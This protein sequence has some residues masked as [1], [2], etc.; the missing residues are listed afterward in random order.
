MTTMLNMPNVSSGIVDSS[1]ISL[2]AKLKKL[3]SDFASFKVQKSAPSGITLDQIQNADLELQGEDNFNTAPTVDH[4]EVDYG[5][6]SSV[7]GS[8]ISYKP[9]VT[10]S[11]GYFPS[12]KAP[13]EIDAEDSFVTTNTIGNKILIVYVKNGVLTAKKS[14]DFGVTWT[15]CNISGN[16][17]ITPIIVGIKIC[18]IESKMYIL[19][20]DTSS[21]NAMRMYKSIDSG[22]SFNSPGIIASGYE[23]QSFDASSDA[24]VLTILYHVNGTLGAYSSLDSGEHW[25]NRENILVTDDSSINVVTPIKISSN[26]KIQQFF[27]SFTPESQSDQ[28]NRSARMYRCNFNT[29]NDQDIDSNSSN[30]AFIN[31]NVVFERFDI[32]SNS[33]TS[34]KLEIYTLMS[35]N[36]GFLSV[37]GNRSTIFYLTEWGVQM[38]ATFSYFDESISGQVDFYGVTGLNDSY[39]DISV[40]N[41]LQNIF[42]SFESGNIAYSSNFGYNFNYSNIFIDGSTFSRIFVSPVGSIINMLTKKNSK[43][44]LTSS[45]INNNSFNENIIHI[46]A[47][48]L[49]KTID[50]GS[51]YYDYIIPSNI[52]HV[53]IDN[54][55]CDNSTF[56]RI[57]FQTSILPSL[58]GRKV[59]I[60]LNNN[61]VDPSVS[62]IIIRTTGGTD[63]YIGDYRIIRD[64][65]PYSI[66]T[67][68]H[69]YGCKIYTSDGTYLFSDVNQIA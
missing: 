62:N 50:N 20:K 38:M 19:T 48:Y 24:K 52:S 5:L 28:E 3:Q 7:Q 11:L 26:G 47:K 12:F 15:N 55:G 30:S 17:E 39:S 1:I 54:D 13:L 65:G 68:N 18:I 29:V 10:S 21:N 59:T 67:I 64:G 51:T 66:D 8:S 32:F 34:T 16:A 69:T 9:S 25:T 4:V 35:G 46:K 14:A 57:T 61:A 31:N 27:V 23:P 60:R 33:N 63:S 37:Y 49:Y 44:Y 45:K 43:C 42:I 56:L 40:S 36:N 58:I 53:Y 2:E 22:G 41:N 6:K